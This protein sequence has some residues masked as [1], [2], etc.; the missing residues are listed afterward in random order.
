MRSH[1]KSL[2]LLFSVLLVVVLAGCQGASSGPKI[3]CSGAWSRPSPKT[4]GA[5]AVYV[6]IKNS[7]AEADRLIGAASSA[8]KTVELHESFMEGDVMKMR[9][10][11]GLDIPAKGTVEL[12]PGSYHIM[13]IDLVEPLAVGQSVPVTLRFTKSGEITLQAEV[14]ES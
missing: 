12:K 1:T 13:L 2:F 11:D 7:G 8:A 9:P 14:R 3:E 6:V 10:V 4:A 5:G